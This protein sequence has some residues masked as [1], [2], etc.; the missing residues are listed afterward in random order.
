M[1]SV[2]SSPS[3]SSVSRKVSSSARL[4][5]LDVVLLAPRRPVLLA[6]CGFGV[7]VLER[8]EFGL[9][10]LRQPRPPRARAAATGARAARGAATRVHATRPARRRRVFGQIDRVLVEV[11]E[12]ARRT[13]GQRRLVPSS[14]F[15]TEDPSRMVWKAALDLAPCCPAVNSAETRVFG[16]AGRGSADD[17]AGPRD[18]SGRHS[19]GGHAVDHAILHRSPPAAPGP[20]KGRVRVPGDKS[21]SH[22]SLIFGRAGGR[23]DPDQRPARRRGRA[24][25]PPRPCAALGATVERTG[26]GAWRVHGV[27]VGGLRRAAPRRSISAIPAP[28]AA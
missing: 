5:D 25:T 12:F 1:M 11:V 16:R 28:A 20:L 7:G 10:G 3:S 23:R 15:A 13:A 24:S 14:G 4:G 2:T 6:A 9:G 21:I 22:R 27:G 8:N 19:T 17:A 26:E 18:R